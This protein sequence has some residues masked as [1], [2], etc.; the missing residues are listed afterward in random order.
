M[1]S[2]FDVLTFKFINFLPK[3][4]F[5]WKFPLLW[6]EVASDQ[7]LPTAVATYFISASNE[8]CSAIDNSLIPAKK[9]VVSKNGQNQYLQTVKRTL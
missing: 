3:D 2:P 5:I 8:Y 6:F 9:G 4:K 1:S 7:Q